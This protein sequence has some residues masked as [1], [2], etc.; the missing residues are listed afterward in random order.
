MKFAVVLQ[1]MLLRTVLFICL[2]VVNFFAIAQT[3][4]SLQ[5]PTDTTELSALQ[6]TTASTQEKK[7]KKFPFFVIRTIKKFPFLSFKPKSQTSNQLSDSLSRQMLVLRKSL[8]SLN[9]IKKSRE[10]EQKRMILQDS[11]RKAVL[12]DTTKKPFYIPDAIR[13]GYDFSY[14]LRGLFSASGVVNATPTAG[15]PQGAAQ[16]SFFGDNINIDLMA[17]MSFGDN[18]YFVT[19]DAGYSDINRVKPSTQNINTT[20]SAT[21]SRKVVNGFRYTNTGTYFRVGL[22]YNFMRRYFNNEAMTIGFRYG[23]SFFKHS[24]ECTIIADSLW[25]IQL[26][27]LPYPPPAGFLKQSGLTANW[28]ELNTGLRVNIWRNFFMGYTIRLM[29]LIG[30]QGNETLLQRN[31]VF[32]GVDDFPPYE[33]F[34]SFVGQ[35]ALVANEI[36]GYGNTEDAFKLGFGIFAAY[37]IP[38]RQRPVVVME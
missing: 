11:A 7:R 35:G 5:V 21:P 17:D 15:V 25:G 23:Q 36:P 19:L 3:Q 26:K 8:D 33:P 1:K 22:E 27:E 28:F 38:L 10:K 37:R 34:K 16:Y 2:F 6:T 12:T 32:E 24:L 13:I 4:D 30:V 20:T 18:K 9:Q 31:F 29:F 14:G